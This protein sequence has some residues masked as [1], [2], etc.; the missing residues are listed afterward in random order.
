MIKEINPVPLT[1]DVNMKLSF[2]DRFWIGGSYRH[3]DSYGVLAGFNI[4]SLITVGY[5]YDIT[6][7]ALNTVSNGTHE[8]VLVYY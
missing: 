6:T 1:Y 4:S 7:S 5:S 3:D 8:I 2:R